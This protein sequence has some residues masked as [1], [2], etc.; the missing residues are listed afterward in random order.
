MVSERADVLLTCAGFGRPAPG[1]AQRSTAVDLLGS[2][3]GQQAVQREQ[4]L[5]AV[6]ELCLL[7]EVRGDP[8]PD[9][10]PGRSGAHGD[11]PP[12]AGPRLHLELSL[13]LV[14]QLAPSNDPFAV[15]GGV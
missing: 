12:P 4:L 2:R 6:G 5:G 1:A 11:V 14:A 3:G 7:L 15:A 8:E 13:S 10:D 9:H